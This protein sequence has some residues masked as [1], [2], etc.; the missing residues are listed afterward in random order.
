MKLEVF[1]NGVRFLYKFKEGVHTSFC[2][3]LEAGA[4]REDMGNI[5]VAHALEHILYKG[6][7]KYNEMQINKKLDNLF[8]MNN[9][10]T[11]YPY[12]IFYGV[13]SKD[14]FK[15]GFD[16]YSDIVLEPSFTE[17]G[18]KEELSVIKEESREW[19]DDSEQ[20]CEDLLLESTFKNERINRIIIGT[21]QYIEN[22]N[23]KK[24]KDF[25]NKFY[26]SEN[27]TV[28]FV[29]SLSYE[30][31]REVVYNRFGRLVKRSV[32]SMNFERKEFNSGIYKEFKLKTDSTKIQ[33]AYD[34]SNLTLE[35]ITLLRIFNMYFGE[36]VSSVLYDEIRTKRGLSYEVYSEV[37]WE[38][39]IEIFKIAINT[40]N[41]HRNEVLKAISD[42]EDNLLAMLDKLKLSDVKH[43]VKRYKLKLS[44]DIERGILLANRSTIYDVMFN[45]PNY[46]QKEL[47]F[48][49]N[50]DLD[51]FK[52]LILSVFEKKALM[53][54][55]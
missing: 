44:L 9:A 21:E 20:Y 37:K 38:K 1:E 19:S 27:M 25:Y 13:S 14:D 24:L 42:I 10:M 8:A 11:N 49:D 7:K 22:I 43:L 40:S 36:G 34:L 23:I 32:E 18:F 55:E 3:G 30:E 17:D 39:S 53:I 46:I 50:I 26:V 52:E 28:S 2:I 35:E 12:V 33:V 29:G 54:L 5:G 41:K 4:N 6:T 51:K 47:D 15:E 31:A 48:D 16:L 45:E